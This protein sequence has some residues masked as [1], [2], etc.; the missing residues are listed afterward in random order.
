MTEINKSFKDTFN[1][2]EQTYIELKERVM[3]YTESGREPREWLSGEF[4]RFSPVTR[5]LA[6]ELGLI[7]SKFDARESE[8]HK[9]F[10]RSSKYFEAV[11]QSPFYRRIIDKPSGYAGDA[12][13]MNFIYRHQF[14]G[15]NP[16]EMLVHYEAVSTESCQSVRNRKDFI[17][18]K[19]CECVRGGEGR[20]LALLQALLWRSR[21]SYGVLKTILS[22]S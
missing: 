8:I 17:Y 2:F 11:Y 16:F 7:Y 12:E 3:T 18:D 4:D 21:N 19:I 20:C 5:S 14:E 10:V 6:H 15:D 22:N 13:I 9:G 1:S